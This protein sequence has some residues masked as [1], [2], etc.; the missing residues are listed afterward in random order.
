VIVSSSTQHQACAKGTV[1]GLGIDVIRDA[2]ERGVLAEAKPF[3]E[4]GGL[5]RALK[6]HR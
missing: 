2:Q 5:L 3:A 6:A 1:E 4:R